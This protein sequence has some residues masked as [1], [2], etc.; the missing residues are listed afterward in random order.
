MNAIV[1]QNRTVQFDNVNLEADWHQA[2]GGTWE[3][4]T[5]YRV[6]E[7]VCGI[8]FSEELAGPDGMSFILFPCTPELNKKLAHAKRYLRNQR[9]VVRIYVIRH[10]LKGELPT[11]MPEIASNEFINSA[12]A[13]E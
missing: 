5:C 3:T 9:D 1:H 4:V 7:T 6:Y 12:L 8:P 2:Y 10:N 11:T 13:E